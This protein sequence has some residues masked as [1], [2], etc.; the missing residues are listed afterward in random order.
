MSPW[1]R[2]SC[3]L[4][5]LRLRS[6]VAGP[7]DGSTLIEMLRSM[8]QAGYP[9]GAPSSNGPIAPPQV[10]GAVP[11][12]AMLPAPEAMQPSKGIAPQQADS[13]PGMQAPRIAVSGQA[14]LVQHASSLPQQPSPAQLQPPEGHAG[15]GQQEDTK[16]S[17]PVNMGDTAPHVAEREQLAVPD[18][19]ADPAQPGGDE[20]QHAQQ[21]LVPRTA[22]DQGSLPEGSAPQQAAREIAQE[23]TRRP[24]TGGVSEHAEVDSVAHGSRGISAEPKASQPESLQQAEAAMPLQLDH[25]SNAPEAPT[26]V[27]GAWAAERSEMSSSHQLEELHGQPPFPGADAVEAAPAGKPL[28]QPEAEAASS[29]GRSTTDDRAPSAIAAA[30]Q[31]TEPSL[32]V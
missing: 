10:P 19:A 22:A 25:A 29:Q 2:Q 9:G 14:A 21:A 27:S 28:A 6:C 32:W 4:R 1:I 12:S 11:D 20:A 17:E 13:A 24:E 26:L 7:M 5:R 16:R 18:A 8:S 15:G 30:L 3:W 23:A 31:Q